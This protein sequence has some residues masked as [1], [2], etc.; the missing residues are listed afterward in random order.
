MQLLNLPPDRVA[1]LRAAPAVQA[2]L[3][4]VDSLRADVHALHPLAP[5][6]EVRVLQKF[7]LDWNYHSNAIEG[8]SLTY[9]E[10]TALLMEGAVAQGKPMKD[11]EDIKGHNAALNTLLDLIHQHEELR[12]HDVRNLHRLLLGQPFQVTAQ[13]PDGQPTRK[14]IYPGEYKDTPNHVLTATGEMHFY[15]TPEE[16]P[17]LMTE[18]F[19]WLAAHRD[20][21]HPLLLSA[22]FHHAFVSIHPFSD[23]NGRMTRLLSNLLLMQAGFPPLIVRQQER[24]EYYGSLR[25]ADAGEPLRLVTFL[26]QHLLRSLDIQLRGAKGEDVSELG[27]LSKKIA[28]LRQSFSTEETVQ[29]TLS[30]TTFRKVLQLSIAPL[31]GRLLPLCHELDDLFLSNRAWVGPFNASAFNME[32]TFNDERELLQKVVSWLDQKDWR[33]HGGSDTALLGADMSIAFSWY[34][35]RMAGHSFNVSH[36]LRVRFDKLD[37]HVSDE[38]TALR[39][40]KLY[41]QLLTSSE[42]E[43]LTASVVD[44]I[45]DEIKQRTGR[46]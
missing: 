2:L 36:G 20:S 25:Q 42:I 5:E 34:H 4:Q 24:T 14:W 1:A 37:Y 30:T 46:A 43:A 32:S 18:L 13:T 35:F 27:D 8:N 6:A 19:D 15:A 7:R 29:E 12:L 41:H 45:L 17:V 38:R 16:T 3:N 28:L 40:S 33:T 10:T 22:L 9:G 23:G 26:G 44:T 39:I 11:H 31:V 21:L